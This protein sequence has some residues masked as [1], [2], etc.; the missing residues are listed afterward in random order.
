MSL[1][2][3]EIYFILKLIISLRMA[4]TRN[5]WPLSIVDNSSTTIMLEY[6]FRGQ[7][8]LLKTCKQGWLASSWFM[9]RKWLIT[10]ATAAVPHRL[11]DFVHPRIAWTRE[12]IIC[13]IQVLWKYFIKWCPVHLFFLLN[14]FVNLL[15]HFGSYLATLGSI[16]KKWIRVW[17]SVAK[18]NLFFYEWWLS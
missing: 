5:L 13:K 10:L 15:G 6:S 2:L 1:V 9:L 17:N 4:G 3:I 18:K 8:G 12:T 16:W 14:F 7:Q 11:V